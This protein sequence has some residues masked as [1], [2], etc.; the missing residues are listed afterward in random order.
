MR[1]NVL[2]IFFQI[3][4]LNYVE[5]L[6]MFKIYYKIYLIKKNEKDIDESIVILN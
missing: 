3:I 2:K 6:H 1:L 5:I 4:Y